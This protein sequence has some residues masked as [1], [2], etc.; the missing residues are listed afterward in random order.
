M[1]IPQSVLHK[2][3]HRNAE[4]TKVSKDSLWWG[5]AATT[6]TCRNSKSQITFFTGLTKESWEQLSHKKFTWG[7]IKRRLRCTHVKFHICLMSEGGDRWT[8]GWQRDSSALTS[9]FLR[10]TDL[11]RG[12]HTPSQ[13]YALCRLAWGFGHLVLSGSRKL[14]QQRHELSSILIIVCFIYMQRRKL[15]LAMRSS[16]D[17]DA[18]NRGEWAG[19]C[20]CLLCELQQLVWTAWGDIWGQYTWWIS[21]MRRDLDV[22]FPAKED[23]RLNK[24]I[25]L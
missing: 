9:N 22:F 10:A 8:D 14:T 6:A 25:I 17:H 13:V 21:L 24:Q 2:W 4:Q 1:T 15:H 18:I 20:L 16:D 23:S 5:D 12:S 3:C 11:H 7:I 19:V